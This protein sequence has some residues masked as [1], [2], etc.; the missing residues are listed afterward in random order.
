MARV[1][2]TINRGW[3]F[4]RRDCPD[5]WFKGFDEGAWADVTLPHDWAVTEPFSQEHSS[6]GGY[7]AGGVGWYRG[8]FTLPEACRGK[9]VW[10]VFDGVYNNAQVWANSYY[11]GKWPYGY[12]TF[13]HDISHAARFGEDENQVSVRVEHAHTAD[14]RWFTGSGIYRKVS[15]LVKEPVYIDQYGVFFTTPEVSADSAQIHVANTLVNETAEPVCGAVRNTLKGPDGRAVAVIESVCEIPAGESVCVAQETMVDKPLLWSPEHPHLYTLVT[16][17]A[18]DGDLMDSE[19]SRVGIRSCRFDADEGFFLNGANIKLKGVCVHHDA[20]CLGAAVHPKVWRR[21]LEL[22]KAAGCNAIRMSHNPHMPELYDLCD[23]MGLMVIDEAFDEWEGPKNK[24]WQGHNVYPPKLYG[25]FEDFPAWHER[26]LSLLVRRDRNHPSVILWS[27]GNEIDYPNDPYG[28]PTFESMM[29]N[30]DANKPAAERRYSPDKPNAERLAPLAQRLK[31]IVK[32]W[33][34]TRPVTAAVAFPELSNLTGYCDTLDVCGYNYKE[35]W[36]AEDHAQYPNRP[37]LGSE[38]GHH[39]AA[40]LAVR[41][42]PFI[43]GQFLWTGI[44]YLG[45]ARGWPIHGSGAGL[46]TTAGFPKAQYWFRRSLWADEPV[47]HLATSRHEDEDSPLLRGTP[48]QW[49]RYIRRALEAP[50]WS[51]APGDLVDI[52]CYTNCPEAELFLN[53]ASQGVRRLADFPEEGC[54]TWQVPFAA[55]ALEVAATAADGSRIA[56]QLFTTGAAAALQARVFGD[57]AIQADGEDIAQI[58]IAVV[59]GDGRLVANASDMVGV[60]VEGAAT[61]LGIDNG[62]LADNTPFFATER[63]AYQGRLIAYVRSNGQAGPITVYCHGRGALK[64]VEVGL[65]AL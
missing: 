9:K 35:Q 50:S 47:V 52:T 6:G 39:Y 10:I 57:V 49:Q 5:A 13:A 40:W 4:H 58:E 21:R 65:T 33:D 53:G 29:G 17:M 25:Y 26:D 61:L 27:I 62:D 16:E 51:Y 64:P 20:G 31:A 48:I 11:L 3:K 41:D 46:L 15:V 18:V 55:G 7:L 42:N 22:L 60:M 8:R 30:N 23:E 14:S 32:Q 2:R 38:N 63:R 34:T 43:S 24:W 19:E 56:S 37:L 44:D 1:Q 12:T 54:I 28:H 45:E 36:Y 59:D